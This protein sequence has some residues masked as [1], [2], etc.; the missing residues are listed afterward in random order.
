MAV[1]SDDWR[2]SGHTTGSPEAPAPHGAT[3]EPNPAQEEEPKREPPRSPDPSGRFLTGWWRDFARATMFLTR[4]PLEISAD[5]AARPLAAAVRGFPLVGLVVGVIGAVVLLAANALG[6]P[7]FASALLAIAAT[8]AVTGGLHE[9]GLADTADG[10]MAGRDREDTLVIMRDSR[11]GAFG[12]LALIVVIGLKT[13]A[14]EAME[15]ASAAAALVAAEIGGRA[16]LPAVLWMVPAA[17]TD[18]LGF[19]AG[20]PAQEE[21]ML[22][23]ALGGV[24]ILIMLGIVTGIVAIVVGGAVAALFTRIVAARV[25]GHTG[26]VLGAVQQ[27]TATTVLLAAAAVF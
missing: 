26:D 8:V 9:D 16:V 5:N 23:S 3:P 6:L 20:R 4:I 14:L 22:A 21:L 1:A 2:T 18:G 19:D 11:I 17:R 12:A 25:G 27:L 7:Q 24:F 15:P 10:V 13:S